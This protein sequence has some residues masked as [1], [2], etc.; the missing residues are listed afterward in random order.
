MSRQLAIFI[1]LIV[2][3]SFG[4]MGWPCAAMGAAMAEQHDC[5]P[6]D[7][8]C[9]SAGPSMDFDQTA[10]CVVGHSS[11]Y[12]VIAPSVHQDPAAALADLDPPSLVVPQIVSPPRLS[13]GPPSPR[14]RPLASLGLQQLLYLHTGR[15]RL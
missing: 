9:D 8:P 2:G 1:L 4:S 10:C 6:P 5:C 3:L 15:L 7:H 12:A 13:Q 14:S 11:S